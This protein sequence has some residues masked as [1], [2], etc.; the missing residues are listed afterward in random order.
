M[1]RAAPADG[2]AWVTGASSG[3]GRALALRLAGQGWRVAVT[4][5]RADALADLVAGSG[6]VFVAYPGD[7]TDGGRMAAVVAAI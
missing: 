2:V 4:A 3:I 7:V 5:R 6:G 1:Y